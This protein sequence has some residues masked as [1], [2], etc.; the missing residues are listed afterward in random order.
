MALRFAA[1]PV[2]TRS[3]PFSRSRGLSRRRSRVRVP[4]LR[5]SGVRWRGRLQRRSA[6]AHATTRGHRHGSAT[7]IGTTTPG[8]AY[9]AAALG[10]RD[11][12][13]NLTVGRDPLPVMN[14][15]RRRGNPV[16]SQPPPVPATDPATPMPVPS[17]SAS[18]S[19]GLGSR[20]PRRRVAV[21]PRRPR[22]SRTT[23]PERRHQR[24]SAA[25]RAVQVLEHAREPDSIPALEELFREPLRVRL[26]LRPDRPHLR[27][28]TARPP[29]ARTRA[30]R[31]RP[32][33]HASPGAVRSWFQGGQSRP[34]TCLPRM[35]ALAHDWR[36]PA[37]LQVF[38]ARLR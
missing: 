37:A 6:E 26:D 31:A 13:I 23:R 32:C 30:S 11:S 3:R 36:A 12:G 25:A 4:S 8:A 2:F 9:G 22:A 18:A 5:S 24:S 15:A 1:L 33:A 38:S 35:T 16:R 7:S 14:C 28:P 10:R 27:H 34:L 29:N 21:R 20:T 19:S 17:A